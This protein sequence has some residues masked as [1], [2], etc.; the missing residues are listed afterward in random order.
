MIHCQ[1]CLSLDNEHLEGCSLDPARPK[2]ISRRDFIRKA[3]I[4]GTAIAVAPAVEWVTVP[5]DLN[6]YP[7]GYVFAYDRNSVRKLQLLDRPPITTTI[8][9]SS[10]DLQ[11]LWR[12]VVLGGPKRLG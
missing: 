10:A 12:K 2:K 5:F 11:K 7:P 3:G 9:T 6:K 8:T 4:L 1:E